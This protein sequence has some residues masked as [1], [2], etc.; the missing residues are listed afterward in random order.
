[1]EV[2]NREFGENGVGLSVDVGELK[3]VDLVIER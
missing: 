1:M 2:R 3:V